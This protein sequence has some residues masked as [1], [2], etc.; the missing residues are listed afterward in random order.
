MSHDDPILALQVGGFTLAALILVLLWHRD[1]LLAS[2][3]TGAFGVHLVGDIL[4]L[5][6]DGL[7]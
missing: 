6:K 2:V 3:F 7:L 5:K 4:R 1:P